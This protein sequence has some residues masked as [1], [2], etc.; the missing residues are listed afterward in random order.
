[1]AELIRDLSG[2][3]GWSH[4]LIYTRTDGTDAHGALRQLL[5]RRRA[6]R[7]PVRMQKARRQRHQVRL[8]RCWD[9]IACR[10]F[11]KG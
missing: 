8:L 6:P 4:C 3:G 11:S 7:R 2:G 9:P 1:M 10:R 5:G